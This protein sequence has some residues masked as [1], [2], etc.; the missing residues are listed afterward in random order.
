MVVKEIDGNRDP[1]TI[2]QLYTNNAY[3]GF[4][5]NIR[6]ISQKKCTGIGP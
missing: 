2:A 6:K 1:M 4:T 5:R 3:F